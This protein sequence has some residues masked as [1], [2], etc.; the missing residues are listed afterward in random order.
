MGNKS[1][2]TK[3]LSKN[4]SGE[5]GGHQAGI[6][7]PKNIKILSFFPELLKDEKNPRVTLIFSDPYGKK[8]AFSFIYYNNRYFGGTR[9][10]FRLTCMTRFMKANN[11][12]A[13]D[14]LILSKDEFGQYHINPIKVADRVPDSVLKLGSAW[15]VIKI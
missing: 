1:A 10:E 6:L 8:W 14:K 12:K 11:L 4:D 13:G 3:V 7:V 15:K 9:N 5:S 2:I